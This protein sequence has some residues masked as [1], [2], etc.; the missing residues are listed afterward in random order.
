MDRALTHV[1]SRQQ[2]DSQSTGI[3]QMKEEFTITCREEGQR[4]EERGLEL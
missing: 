1:S 3:K 2:R 4:P